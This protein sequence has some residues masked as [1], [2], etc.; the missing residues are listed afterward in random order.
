[1][2]ESAAAD[3]IELVDED[4][5]TDPHRYYDRWRARGPVHRVQLVSGSQVWVI[6]GYTEGRAALADPRLRKNAA[7]L[8]ELFR[9]RNV[10]T[11]S[12]SNAQTLAAH[13]LNSDPPEHTRLR[14][15]VSRAFLP[16]RVATLRPRIEEITAALL[17][18][19]AAHDE[20]D[21]MQVF[22]NPLPVTVICELL[23]VP[24]DERADFQEWTRILVS[25]GGTIEERAAA[26][27]G[28]SEY[29]RK[30]MVD[31]RAHP[32]DDLLSELV[33]PTP[34]GDRLDEQELVAMAF[35]LLVAGH[36]TTVNL[37]GN[38]T[39]ALLRNRPQWDALRAD[40]TA[41]PAAIEEFLRHDGPVGWTTLRYTHEPVQIAGIDI[42]AGEFIYVALSAANRDPARFDSG[43]TLDIAANATG[44]LAFGHGIHFCVG[45]PL[46][47]L[48]A[49]IAFKSL[50]T[51]FPDLTLADPAFEPSWQ[52]SLLIRGMSEL[53]VRP[54][55]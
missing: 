55:G 16:R 1:M 13:M 49:D 24:F 14:K 23:G 30:L 11:L 52:H 40:P 39:H 38:G 21:L 48:E 22:A 8:Y 19:M 2:V 45:A 42:P 28:M 17:D 33:Q 54:H 26:T 53:P 3:S 35:L 37:I 5:Y 51:R 36:E 47:R 4:F 29:L 25:S 9:Q 46:A 12:D 44:H 20:I 6:V 31:K 18:D 15:L 34:D 43:A 41:I 27:L 7:D 50:L 10:R 32:G